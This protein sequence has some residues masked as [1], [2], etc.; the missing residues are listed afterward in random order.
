MGKTQLCF[1]TDTQ[2]YRYNE[3]RRGKSM[4][5]IYIIRQTRRSVTTIKRHRVEP[6]CPTLQI[7]V[8]IYFIF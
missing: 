2:V 4:C 1:M 8:K 7:P 3:K 6:I 5:L